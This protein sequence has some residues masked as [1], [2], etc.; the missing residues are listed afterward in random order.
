MG[1]IPDNK[2]AEIR[3]RTDIVAVIGEH[4]PLRRAGVNHLGLCPFHAEKSPS[5]NVNAQKQFFY[6]FGCHKSGDVFQFLMEVEGKSFAEVARELARRAGV[7]IV[8]DPAL[9]TPER[10][11]RQK[12]QE[13]DKARL[14]R[15]HELATLFFTARLKESARAQAYIEGRGIGSAVCE[16]FRLGYAPE[17]WDGLLRYLADKRVPPELL[18]RSGLVVRRERGGGHYDRFRDRIIFPLINVQGDVIA[19]GGRSLPGDKPAA[20]PGEEGAAGAKYINSPESVLYRKGDNLYGL[21]AAKESIRKGRQVVLVEGNFDVLSLHEHGIDNA[22]A[23]MGTALTETQVR[24]LKRLLSDEGHVILMLDGDRAGRSA[25]MKDILLFT[26]ESLNDLAL[27]T[28][29][30]VD[31]RVVKLPDGEDPDTYVRHHLQALEKRL[32]SAKPAVD[33]V[34]D[35]AIKVAENDSVAEKAKVLMQVAPLLQAIWKPTVFDMYVDKLANSLALPPTLVLRHVRGQARP[36]SAALA[37]AAANRPPAKAA[38]Q[39]KLD[40]LIRKLVA[41]LGDHPQL[42]C[43]LPD[44]IIDRLDDLTIAEVLREARALC[45]QGEPVTGPRLIELS[46]PEVRGALAAAALAG[47]FSRSLHPE[48]ALSEILGTLRARFKQRE[49]AELKQFL[50]QAV[51]TGDTERSRDLNLQINR[52]LKETPPDEQR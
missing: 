23:P 50:A 2:I 22:V 7:E 41:L 20:G 52:L 11:Q 35:E 36:A 18:E 28:G 30:E 39:R 5:F 46:P 4:V 45:A 44:D 1:L 6:C 49:I 12:Q 3:E 37:P 32:K 29:S 27:F 40:P 17:G 16:R 34:L 51:K 21:H 48:L 15:V 24:V 10:R 9:S 31:V 19:F 13:D 43:A 47:E 38:P 14:L 42:V 25:T 8:E 26:Q 33:Y